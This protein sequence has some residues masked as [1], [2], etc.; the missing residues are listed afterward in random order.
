MKALLILAALALAASANPF[1]KFSQKELESNVWVVLAAGSDGWYNYRHQADVCHYYQVMRKQ[2]IPEEHIIVMM[3]DDIANNPSNKK[4]GQ[5]FNEPGGPDVYAG[6]PKDY[7]G[8][9]VSGNNFLAVLRGEAPAGGSGKRLQSTSK[10]HVFVFFDDH[11]TNGGLCFPEGCTIKKDNLQATLETMSQKGMFGDLVF[12]VE[13]CFAG[14]VFYKMQIPPNVYVV[15]ASPVGESSFAYNYDSSIGTY[16]ADIFSFIAVHD[17]ETA[18]ISKSLQDEFH[19]IQTDIQNYSQP[20]QYGDLNIP[21][22]F[23]IGSFFQSSSIQTGSGRRVLPKDAVP[24]WDV[25][26]EIARR[27]YEQNPTEENRIALRR[28]VDARDRIDAISQAINKALVTER[29]LGVPPCTTCDR[30]CTC[31]QYCISSQSAKYCEFECCNER[32][33]YEDPPKDALLAEKKQSCIDQ[34][35]SYFLI[36]C[37][38]DHPYLR[39]VEPMIRHACKSPKANV[40]AALD[41]IE[42][43]CAAF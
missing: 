20:C 10:D 22:A 1:A 28:E 30:S 31:Y 29:H 17:I 5:I 11:G 7:T 43:Q 32:S 15:T 2:G 39:S 34:L 25:P 42:K 4:K 37:G 23:T 27:Q 35:T 24:S 13:A 41:V 9:L 19:T 12:Y 16:L 18:P 36:K 40:P 6:V 38:N 21:T 3:K 8:K 14:S 33:C 26:L